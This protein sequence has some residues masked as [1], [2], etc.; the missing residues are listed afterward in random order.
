MTPSYSNVYDRE[1]TLLNISLSFSLVFIERAVYL[2]KSMATRYKSLPGRQISSDSHTMAD[3]V[4][5]ERTI[6][7]SVKPI[8][9]PINLRAFTFRC[10]QKVRWKQD[11]I[12]AATVYGA[13]D[14]YEDRGSE[15][16][17]ADQ[18]D[19]PSDSEWIG[20]PISRSV[21]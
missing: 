7:A 12:V 14:E 8:C 15:R 19:R 5:C 16:I 1:S 18:F 3:S 9:L 2:C 17:G 10:I 4:V 6:F 21:P 20:L 13:V 11:T